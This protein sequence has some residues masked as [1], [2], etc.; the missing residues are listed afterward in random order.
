M[1]LSSLL[2]FLVHVLIRSSCMAAA[3]T[4]SDVCIVYAE[5]CSYCALPSAGSRT[6]QSAQLFAS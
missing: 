4:S 6:V 1:V 2:F 5:H 3:L